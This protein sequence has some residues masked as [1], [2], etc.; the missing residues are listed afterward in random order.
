MLTRTEYSWWNCTSEWKL[1]ALLPL[2]L[3]YVLHGPDQLALTPLQ[4]QHPVDKIAR[5]PVNC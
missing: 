2:P 1:I 4:A 5:R 3:L